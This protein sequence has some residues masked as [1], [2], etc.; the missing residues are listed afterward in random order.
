MFF[1]LDHGVYLFLEGAFGDEAVD[2]HIAVLS[3]AVGAVGGLGFYRGIPPQ[4]IVDDMSGRGEV[5]ADAFNDR[6]KT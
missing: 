6:M 2:L 3:D 5:E 4:V 1:V